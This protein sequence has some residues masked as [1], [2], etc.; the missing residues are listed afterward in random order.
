[1]TSP[2]ELV[3]DSRCGLGEGPTWD[4]AARRLLWVDV[5]AS[6]IHVLD[7]RAHHRVIGLESAAT[8][9]VP[10]DGGGLVAT[11]ANTVVLLG[12]DGTERRV[13]AALP[14]AGDGRTNDG[15]CDPH[16]RLWVGTVDRSGA[17]A[18]GLFCVDA[19][20]AVTRVREGVGM[21][22]GLDW[23]PDG[24]RCYYVDTYTRRVDVCDL[25]DDGFPV[26]WRPLVETEFMPDGLTVDSLGGVW[27]AAWDGGAVHRFT[28]D[29]RLDR[30]VAVPGGF[31]T[32]CAFGGATTLYI[33]SARVD[34]P[35]GELARQPHAGGLF[36][37]DVGVTGRGYT[38]FRAPL[39]GQ[40]VRDGEEPS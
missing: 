28:P 21:S 2:V 18:A 11:S 8:M 38:P 1:M 29:G 20:G 37:V 32:S 27:V 23:S 6:T 25:D 12:D 13:L 31:V 40:G 34:L 15:R 36:A 10:D 22:N 19:D 35:A 17:K 3:V 9:V 7:D 5:E 4:A 14:R 16:G 33:T 30:T 26:R 39:A 24:R